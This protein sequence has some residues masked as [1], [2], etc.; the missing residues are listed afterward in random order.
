MQIVVVGSREYIEQLSNKARHG[1][2]PPMRDVRKRLF[3]KV[4]KVDAA[5]MSKLDEDL[6]LIASVSPANI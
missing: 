1:I 6:L 4:P 3:A 5:A 2:T